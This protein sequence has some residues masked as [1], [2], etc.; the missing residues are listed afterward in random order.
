MVVV[1]SIQGNAFR[2]CTFDLK[3]LNGEGSSPSDCHLIIMTIA[4]WIMT[5]VFRA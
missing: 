5:R 4:A 3:S 1:T 2:A